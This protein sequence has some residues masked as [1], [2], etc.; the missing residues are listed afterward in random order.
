M[1]DYFVL[2]TDFYLSTFSQ[3]TLDSV[4]HQVDAVLITHPDLLHMGALPYAV[5]LGLDCPIYG[6]IP[7]FLMGRVFLTDALKVPKL[8]YVL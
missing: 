5:K 4:L 3:T 6:T 1:A 7:T 8:I 2:E